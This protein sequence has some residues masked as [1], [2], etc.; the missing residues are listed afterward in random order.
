MALTAFLSSAGSVTV[1]SR[2]A[3]EG[4]ARIAVLG[5]PGDVVLLEAAQDSTVLTLSGQPVSAGTDVAD[6]LRNFPSGRPLLLTVARGG[7]TVRVTGR[8]APAVLPGEADFMFARQRESGRVDAVR[9]GQTVELNTRGVG[10]LTLLLSP[11][12]FD[13]ARPVKVT[14]NGKTVFEGVVQRDIRTLLKWAARDDDR[15]M[16]FGAELPIEVR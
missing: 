6:A 13:L 12:Q 14:V 5:R 4:E 15:T 8:Y 11:D 3:L 16:L 9:S 2:T 10:G 7:E 1:N